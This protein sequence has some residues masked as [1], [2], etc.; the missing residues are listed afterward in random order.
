MI[1][2]GQDF[3]SVSAVSFG[4]QP[5]ASYAV[6]SDTA[7]KAVVPRATKPGAVPVTVTTVSG[8]AAGAF[9]YKACVVP[10]VLG[11]KLKGAKK[12]IRKAGCK[13][14]NV[15]FLGD[16]TP[17]TGRVVKQNPKAGKVRVPGTKVHLKLDD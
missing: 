9:T 15:K 10:N 3:V 16:S 8:S 5:A 7:I 13:V 2:S 6:L 4:S 14:G 1:I 17:K 11:K 12:R